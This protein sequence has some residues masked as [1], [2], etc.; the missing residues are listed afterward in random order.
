MGIIGP[1][2]EYLALNEELRVAFPVSGYN[3][4]MPGRLYCGTSGFAY[5]AWKPDFYP[6]KLAAKKFLSYYASRLNAVEINY[7]FRRLPSGSTLESWVAGTPEHFQ[8]ALKGHQRITHFDRL[9]VTEFCQ[10]FFK[11]IDPLRVLKR[12]GPVLFQ[13]PPNLPRD[14]D[15]LAAFLAQ[16]PADLRLA[17]EFRNKSWFDDSIFQ[18]LAGRRAALCLAESNKLETPP[19]ITSDFVYFRLRKASYTPEERREIAERANAMQSEGRDVYLFF[20]H[21]DTP[22]GALYSEELLRSNP[23]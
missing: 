22:A 12:L 5:A 3:A 19:V 17:F 14:P 10:V 18:I 23:Q 7:T 8:F 13:L 9:A 20:K 6:Q 16:A 1:Q 11:A 15:L 2:R 21:E 4:Q